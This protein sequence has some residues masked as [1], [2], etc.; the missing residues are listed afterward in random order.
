MRL[1]LYL[2]P[3][4]QGGAPFAFGGEL[5]RFLKL[6]L[7]IIFGVLDFGYSAYVR[8][9]C[10][11]RSVSVVAHSFGALAGLLLGFMVLKNSKKEMW[12][13]SAKVLCGWIFF[14]FVGMAFGVNLTGSRKAVGILSTK[15]F[16]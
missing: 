14:F 7:I 15:R 12:E 16:C 9:N 11:N 5:G 6:A 13:R 2:V 1:I 4:I 10:I 3:R 8:Y